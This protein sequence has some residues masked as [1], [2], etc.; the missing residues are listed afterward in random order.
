MKKT[1][2]VLAGLIALL[3]PLMACAQDAQRKPLPLADYQEAENTDPQ[4][5]Y[6]RFVNNENPLYQ[7]HFDDTQEDGWRSSF[8]I[9]E[10]NGVPFTL[11]YLQITWYDARG[12]VLDTYGFTQEELMEIGSVVLENGSQFG[13]GYGSS[14]TPKAKWVGVEVEGSDANGNELAFTNLVELL[15]EHRPEVPLD[16]FLAPQEPQEGKPFIAVGAD[17]NPV[18]ISEMY[19]VPE[20]PYWWKFYVYFENT[21]STAFTVT[22]AEYIYYNGDVMANREQYGVEALMDLSQ[23][24]EPVLEPGERWEIE[25]FTPLQDMT[26]LGI[27]LTGTDESGAEMSFV[28]CVSLL[29]E[30]A[31][32]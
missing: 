3:L 6:V 18:W 29:H 31:K 26:Q 23:Q 4:K 13:L 16:T 11:A 9:K 10:V 2:A 21:G 24:R 19:L 17:P 15:S 25:T 30:M 27:R 8:Y 7:M 1:L 5:A 22:G 14:R 28:G 20:E 32:P 12:H